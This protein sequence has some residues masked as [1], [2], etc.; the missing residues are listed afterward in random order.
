MSQIKKIKSIN[1]LSVFNDFNWDQSVIVNGR[2]T[3]FNNVNIIYG[4]NYSGKT[5]LS[6]IVRAIETHEITNKYD[7]GDFIIEF[8]DD[9]TINK[10]QIES[11][12]NHQI[13]VF[14]EDFVKEK[15]LFVT[16]PEQGIAPFAV[17]GDNV[18]VEQEIQELNKTL[19]SNEERKETALFLERKIA[20]GKC[21]RSKQDYE[22]VNNSL[23]TTLSKKATDKSIG[24]KYNPE[25]DD[26][27]YNISKIEK[28]L[29]ESKEVHLLSD[30]T[31]EQLR[32]CI[33]EDVL[34]KPS[35]I[36]L[37]QLADFEDLN[38]KSKMLV[39]RPVVSAGKIEELVKNAIANKWVEDGLKI[40][41]DN[42]LDHCL[43]CGQTISKTRW[44]VLENHFDESSK[45]LKKEISDLISNIQIEIKK[46][47]S[48][49]EINQQEY[50][51][52]FHSEIKSL[53][54]TK[55][56]HIDQYKLSL[57]EIQKQLQC[58]IDD[59]LNIKS[60]TDVSFQSDNLNNLYNTLIQLRDRSIQYGEKLSDTQKLNKEKLRLSEIARFRVEIN[61]DQKV[62]EIAEKKQLAD[63]DEQ[64]YKN[65]EKKI[66]DIQLEIKAKERLRKNE[67]EGAV[68]VNKFIQSFFGH[69]YLELR[70]VEGSGGVYFD[71]F[72]DDK[73]AYHLSEGERNIVA[74]SYFI[75]KLDDIDTRGE[76]P[77]IWIDDPISS[78]D[79]NHIFHIFS[80]IDTEIVSKMI[81][82]QLFITTHNLDFLRY[83]HRI[84]TGD[85]NHIMW[86]M[87][88]REGE[89]STIHMMPKYLKEHVTEFNYLFHQIYKCSTCNE[90]ENYELFYNFGNNARK[91]L[92][93]YLY[94]RY[95]DNERNGLLNKMKKFF[96]DDSSATVVDRI[97]NE[98][99]HL[100][101]LMERGMLVHDI[102]EIKKVA[103]YILKKIQEKDP[104][105]Y[106]SLL[107]SIGE[108][109]HQ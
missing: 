74:F 2:P 11:D 59:I 13:R 51:A 29:K 14:N 65:I 63:N 101:G 46:A 80:L 94:Y 49:L 30:K 38:R 96:S 71:V 36:I 77:I 86:L 103:C 31:I 99:S 58:R 32:I 76:Q 15:L 26:P 75:A 104:D 37:P 7:G 24:I 42:N 105:Q 20:L 60:Y 52:S 107:D 53:L 72:R 64:S 92:E 23:N 61:Y 97:D 57:L 48:I 17:F 109:G 9:S 85:K 84:H 47:D 43:F 3:S 78:L 98:M 81:Y 18:S 89:I 10:S 79:Y 21:L 73:K 70:A 91:F 45:A 39:E 27:N 68:K 95:P 1:N 40:H 69:N 28:E 35:E 25:F 88:E 12:N 34:K 33:K 106:Q 82:S 6:R 90:T 41:K 87:I 62:K 102:P 100:E 54:D 50:Y 16:N 55:Q 83:L 93:A 4:R 66:S 67:E 22:S 108:S 44:E 56:K 5:T 8:T 19:G